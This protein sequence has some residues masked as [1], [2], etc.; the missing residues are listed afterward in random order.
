MSV[1]DTNGVSIGTA[2][3]TVTGFL[4]AFDWVR[5]NGGIASATWGS[6]TGTIADQTDLKDALNEK[7]DAPVYTNISAPIGVVFRSKN[8]NQTLAIKDQSHKVHYLYDDGFEIVKRDF[9]PD[10]R[11]RNVLLKYNEPSYSVW[12]PDP[13]EYDGKS[14]TFIMGDEFGITFRGRFRDGNTRQ[15]TTIDEFLTVIALGGFWRT[16]SHGVF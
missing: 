11:H 4:S 14:F 2:S 6:I 16:T 8:N 5:F 9:M 15:L 3:A 1:A 13:Q 7:S 10:W 12:L